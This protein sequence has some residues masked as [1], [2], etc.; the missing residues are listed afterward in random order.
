MTLACVFVPG[1]NESCILTK[2]ASRCAG[3]RY[4]DF[5]DYGNAY[6]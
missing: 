5:V 2:H 4:H 6:R 3:P 1:R